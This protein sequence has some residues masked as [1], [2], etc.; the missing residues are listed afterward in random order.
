MKCSSHSIYV[1]LS[2]IRV[3]ACEHFMH[4]FPLSPSYMYVRVNISCFCAL[5][6]L[7][8]SLSVS[9]SL[10]LSLSMSLSLSLSLFLFSLV[11]FVC[12][13]R[14]VV[15]HCNTNGAHA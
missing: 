11:P 5:S 13:V 7:C 15:V 6:S 3:C 12:S 4:L 10:S 9:L 1:H 2:L 8:L 14:N